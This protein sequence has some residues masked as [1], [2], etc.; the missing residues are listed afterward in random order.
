MRY[1][2][3]QKQFYKKRS[4]PTKKGTSEEE[5][6]MKKSKEGTSPSFTY[7]MM[8]TSSVRIYVVNNFLVYKHCTTKY[9]L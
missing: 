7:A 8:A 1:T 3:K 9:A 2:T 4:R 6:A 5:E